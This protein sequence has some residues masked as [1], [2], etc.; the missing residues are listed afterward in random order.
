MSG[1]PVHP[2]DAACDDRGA[3]HRTSA[4]WTRLTVVLFPK[5]LRLRIKF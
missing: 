3:Q 4:L 1:C 5:I 2:T